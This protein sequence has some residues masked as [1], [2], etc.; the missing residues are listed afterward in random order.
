MVLKCIVN[1]ILVVYKTLEKLMTRINAGIDPSLLHRR[2]LIAEIREITMVPAALKRSLRTK[3]TEDIMRSI[4]KK[5]TLNSGHVLF[6]YNKL[7]YLENRFKLLCNEMLNRDYI[8]DESRKL[9]FCGFEAV[10][11][12]DWESSE[13]DN[14]IVWERINLRISEKPH[15]YL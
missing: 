5:F 3:S 6:F 1:L 2:H 13:E 15:L 9:A 12:G 7:R 11:Y 14:K 8:A 10:W 4:P